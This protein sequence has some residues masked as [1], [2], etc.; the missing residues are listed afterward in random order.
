MLQ[1]P[2]K[3][4]DIKTFQPLLRDSFMPFAYLGQKLKREDRREK[5]RNQQRP[6]PQL[7]MLRLAVPG[8]QGKQAEIL[9]QGAEAAPA[10]VGVMR[11]L[12]VA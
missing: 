12:G 9:G 2:V 5:D 4:W 7:E 10:V 3:D 11:D 8:G 1:H 6:E